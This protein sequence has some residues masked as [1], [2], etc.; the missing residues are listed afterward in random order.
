MGPVPYRRKVRFERPR[1][2]PKDDAAHA[3]DE[4]RFLKRLGGEELRN[5]RLGHGSHAAG[6]QVRD[7]LVA[8]GAAPKS[9]SWQTENVQDMSPD[10][11]RLG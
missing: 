1:P 4:F 5:H 7:C 11:R 3:L 6:V 2:L 10:C 9:V 8:A